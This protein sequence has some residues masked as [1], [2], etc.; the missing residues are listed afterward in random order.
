MNRIYQGR[1]TGVEIPIEVSLP[2]KG[3]G[4]PKLETRWLPLH[5][6]LKEAQRLQDEV[7]PRIL[8]LG[9]VIGDLTTK[10]QKTN[11][12]ENQKQAEQITEDITKAKTELRELRKLL[13]EPWQT[14]LWEHHQLFQDMVNYYTVALAAMAEG[15]VDKAGASTAMADFAAQVKERWK[16]FTHKGRQRAGLRQSLCRILRLPDDETSTWEVCTKKILEGALNHFPERKDEKGMDVFHQVIAEM[17][18]E[19]SRGIPQK[20]SK[21]D[22]PWLCW[23]DASGETPAKSS[24]R[25]NHGI[26]DFLSELFNADEHELAKLAKKEVADTFLTS[27]ESTDDENEDSTED[28]VSADD[29]ADGLPE[30]EDDGVKRFVGAEAVTKLRACITTAK[31][32]LAEDTFKTNFALMGGDITEADSV[33]D[34]IGQSVADKENECKEKPESLSFQKWNTGGKNKDNKKVELFALFAFDGGSVFTAILLKAQI[35]QKGYLNQLL[36]TDPA[37]YVAIVEKYGLCGPVE[38]KDERVNGKEPYK[39]VADAK[40][41]AEKAAEDKLPETTDTGNGYTDYIQ[42][43]RDKNGIVFPGFTATS[44]QDRLSLARFQGME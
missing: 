44:G 8:E 20:M 3:R 16:S 31:Q 40:A 4:K 15:A 30:G 22:W 14:A 33:F 5:S 29:Q 34:R 26:H 36:K 41:K 6:D 11:A 23:K 32:L 24:Y 17:F 10:L 25:K 35:K 27:I 38:R 9:K 42:A 37:G 1:V 19:K 21:S 12:A 7:K 2:P 28:A 39:I 18:P 13:G 43:I